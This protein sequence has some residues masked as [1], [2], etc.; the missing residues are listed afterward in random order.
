M[1][2]RRFSRSLERWL[3]EGPERAPRELLESVLVGYPSI[4]QRGSRDRPLW[5]FAP[6]AAAAT[7]AIA[8]VGGVG[9]LS[10]PPEP[11]VNQPPPSVEPTP[12]PPA[13]PG[14]LPTAYPHEV[15]DLPD[16]FQGPFPVVAD[17]S[18]WVSIWDPGLVT[19]VDL[20]SGEV[21]ASIEVG[22]RPDG[23]VVDD[24]GRVWVATADEGGTI[25]IIDPASNQ[26]ADR[27]PVGVEGFSLAFLDGRL[28][29]ASVEQDRIVALDVARREI[30]LDVAFDGVGN[31]VATDDGVWAALYETPNIVRFDPETLEYRLIDT[32]MTRTNLL[33]LTEDEVW[34]TGEV[35]DESVVLSRTTEEIVDR[36]PGRRPET[37]VVDGDRVLMSEVGVT[38]RDPRIRVFDR[39]THDE[40]DA[41][42]LPFTEP[43]GFVRHGTS[44]WITSRFGLLRLDLER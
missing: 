24:D 44:L 18:L 40:I 21:V 11:T 14:P 23:L 27:I 35:S 3:D 39:V 26:V 42:P 43:A 36:I 31:L 15:I 2:D 5:R 22:L 29:I 41:Y 28:W 7:L 6:I 38:V 8:A 25:A 9:L 16:G 17:G 1:T 12:S 32:G 33:A 4:P 30:V 37:I 13:T 19:R 34:V 10:R 20:D